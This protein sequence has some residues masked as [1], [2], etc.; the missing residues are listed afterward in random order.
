ME[1]IY[2]HNKMSYL[3]LYVLLLDNQKYLLHASEEKD[4]EKII[5]EC[6]IVYEYLNQYST[7]AIKEQHRI[8]MSD[9]LLI[10]YYVKMYM[11][12]HGIDNVRGGSYTSEILGEDA[13]KIIAAELST[14]ETKYKNVSTILTSIYANYS[15]LSDWDEN[16]ISSEKVKLNA[17]LQDY[18]TVKNKLN[19]L[20]NTTTNA[21]CIIDRDIFI[22]I[23]WLKN[24]ILFKHYTR[25]EKLLKNRIL[26]EEDEYY[27]TV[28][29]K[30]KAINKI[31]HTILGNTIDYDPKI[32]LNEPKIVFDKFFYHAHCITNWETDVDVANY[33]ISRFEHMAYCVINK[34]DEIE[35]DLSHYQPYF[36]ERQKYSIRYLDML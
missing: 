7:I 2:T 11:Q 22:N 33:L 16:V 4:V 18:Y 1:F 17:E 35:F 32:F 3:N 34:I 30:F 14:T 13:K 26:K 10:D 29:H 9:L 31:F 27:K 8:S 24:W 28:L 6:R 21:N 23:R 36:E 5:K 25:T 12:K 19:E 15:E 20:K